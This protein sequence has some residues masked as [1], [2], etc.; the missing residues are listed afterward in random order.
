MYTYIYIYTW[1]IYG[2][3]VGSQRAG[4][5]LKRFLEAVRFILAE[6]EPEPSHGD[7]IRGL[8]W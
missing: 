3:Q 5:G 6:F 8:G 4:R 7:P 2:P 1:N